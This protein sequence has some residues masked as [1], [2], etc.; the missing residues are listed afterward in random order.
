DPPAVGTELAP[1]ASADELADDPHV[2]RGDLERLGELARHARHVL[3][4]APRGELLSLPLRDLAVRLEAAVRDRGDAVAPLDARVGRREGGLGVPDALLLAHARPLRVGGRVVD[5][6][7]EDVVLDGDRAERVL[8]GPLA[9][10]R[11]GRDLVVRPLDLRALTLE[12]DD[13]LD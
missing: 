5:R 13:R 6:V 8:R 7:R 2:A 9:R 3:R 10:R 4:R 11:D 1:E 12:D